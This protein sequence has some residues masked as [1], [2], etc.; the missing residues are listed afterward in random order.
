MA[1]RMVCQVVCPA[2][3][4]GVSLVTLYEQGST[5]AEWKVRQDQNTRIERDEGT[6]PVAT[7]SV[8]PTD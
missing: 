2:G 5:V 4:S 6:A 8:V 7:P 1:H 3:S